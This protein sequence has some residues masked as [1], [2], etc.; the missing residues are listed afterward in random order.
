MLVF[1]KFLKFECAPFVTTLDKTLCVYSVLLRA[2]GEGDTFLIPL[3]VLH[4]YYQ[5]FSVCLLLYF[6][7]VI[8]IT[9]K[10]R[11]QNRQIYPLGIYMRRQVQ[12]WLH[13]QCNIWE[14]V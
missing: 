7:F 11:D 3:I 2:D 10:Y 5:Y 6:H 12:S 1:I 8:D 14:R 4:G 13:Y 9:Q